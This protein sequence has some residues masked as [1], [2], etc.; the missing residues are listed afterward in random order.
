MGAPVYDHYRK[1]GKEVEAL[2]VKLGFGKLKVKVNVGVGRWAE[3]PWI[4]IRHPE[5]AK[6]YD[7]GVFVV[8]FFAPD[9]DRLYLALIQGVTKASSFELVESTRR[10]RREIEKPEG[11]CGWS[12]RKTIKKCV[13]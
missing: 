6:N 5:A 3:V 9:F 12:S 2:A 1:L 11:F 4:G 10:L 13:L 8:Y 7:E